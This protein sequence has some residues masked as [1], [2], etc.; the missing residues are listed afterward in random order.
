MPSR[1]W[2]LSKRAGS[3]LWSVAPGPQT[4]E[5]AARFAAL[6]LVVLPF[7]PEGPFGPASGIRP[8]DLWALVLIFSGLS[9]AGFSR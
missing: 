9:F 5:A 8:Q 7:L 2:C 6:A 4:Q 1:R 3:T